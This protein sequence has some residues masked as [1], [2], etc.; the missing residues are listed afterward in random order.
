[1]I[2]K[3]FTRVGA[4][5]DLASGQ[6]TFMLEMTEVAHILKNA[7]ARSL[8]VYDEVGRG[9]STYDGMSIARAVAEYTLGKKVG[10]KTLFATH[11]HELT[12][13]ENTVDGV[14]NYNVA[15]K[16][17]GE[18]IVFLRKIVKGGTDESYGIE[19]A[20]L[21]GVPKAV[22]MRAREILK[23]INEEMPNRVVNVKKTEDDRNVS[24]ED[25]S[26]NDVIEKIKAIPAKLIALKDKVVGTVTAKVSE[27]TL[28]VT[29]TYNETKAKIVALYEKVKAFSVKDAISGLVADTTAKITE[30]VAKLKA[31]VVEEGPLGVVVLVLGTIVLPVLLIIA[32]VLFTAIVA[33]ITVMGIVALVASIFLG[34]IV[35]VL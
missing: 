11:Y 3:V 25:I 24:F 5:D 32:L 35:L 1:V 20:K 22:V 28:K 26:K 34:L 23:E 12:E 10:A 31:F 2:D 4:S 27:I 15:A 21:A 9:T 19:V 8:I 6:S 7:T 33:L 17:R 13:L 18:E 30:L 14:V 29:Q 16:K